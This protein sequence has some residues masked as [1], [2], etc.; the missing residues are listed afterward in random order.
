V[1]EPKQVAPKQEQ[2]AKAPEQ[3]VTPKQEIVAERKAAV[4]RIEK[5]IPGPSMN[6][7]GHRSTMQ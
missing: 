3:E 6:G 1:P 7:T 2:I 4:E 5:S